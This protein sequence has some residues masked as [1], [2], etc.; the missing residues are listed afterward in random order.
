MSGAPVHA[1]SRGVQ[2][3]LLRKVLQPEDMYDSMAP[4]AE[5]EGPAPEDSGEQEL[6][7]Q[8]SATGDAGNVTPRYEA[9]LNQATQRGGEALPAE[10]QS[11]M[12]SRLGR[13]LSP[14]R[15]HSDSVAHGL[16]REVNARAFTVGRDIFF[17]QSEYQP[18]SQDGRRLLAHELTHVMQ[19]ADGRLSRQVQRTPC[20]SYPGY[21]A[22]VN[23]RTYNCAGLGLRTYNFTSPPDAV[24]REMYANFFNPVCPVG[25]CRGGHVRFWL[26][27]YDIRMEDDRG[28]VLKPTWHDFHFVGGR[29]DAAGNDLADVYSKNGPRP[30][31]GPGTGASFRPAARDRALDADDNPI[32][33]NGRPVSKV[34][35]NMREVVTCAGCK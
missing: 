19:Q 13:D 9:A 10:T 33:A 4:F 15:V 1:I 30:I 2:P 29:T 12:E 27:D 31:H 21:D 25:K 3:K 7:M 23:R 17:G 20:S 24:Y 8:R 32:S 34:R 14:V 6:Q 28:T 11:F 35:T 18:F 5:E 22:S 16:A 26:W